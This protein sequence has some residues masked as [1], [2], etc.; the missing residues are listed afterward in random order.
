M[1]VRPRIT[2]PSNM[3][4]SADSWRDEL[5]ESDVA[6]NVV[7]NVRPRITRPSVLR[8][9]PS[10]SGGKPPH[11]TTLRDA[12]RA[13]ELRRFWSAPIPRR[14]RGRSSCLRPAG[15]GSAGLRV[16]YLTT[17][18]TRARSDG[19]IQCVAFLRGLCVLRGGR[20]ALQRTSGRIAVLPPILN[21]TFSM[22]NPQCAMTAPAPVA[23]RHGLGI[24]Y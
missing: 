6:L 14:F 18:L 23:G 15:Y 21:N 1:N 17:K 12:R 13:S 8:S 10:Q 24:E 11:S 22:L 16:G 4:F 9:P 7:R 5:C 20:E 3:R 2:R 19:D